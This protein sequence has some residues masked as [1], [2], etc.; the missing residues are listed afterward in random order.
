MSI[1]IRTHVSCYFISRQKTKIC[2]LVVH[3]VR[4]AFADDFVQLDRV[5]S[6]IDGA[7][8]ACKP[9]SLFHYDDFDFEESTFEDFYFSIPRLVVYR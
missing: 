5:Y 3:A 9:G 7:I 6:N 8:I 4:S 1:V 2:F